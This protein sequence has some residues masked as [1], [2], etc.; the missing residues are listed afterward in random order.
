MPS[1]GKVSKQR[2]STCDKPL[3]DLF[4]EVVKHFD[5]FV[6]CGTRSKEDQEAAFN[7][8]NSKLHYP[9]S[10]HNNLPSKAIDVA[11]YLNGAIN[12]DPRECLYFAGVVKGIAAMMGIKIR[13]GGDWDSDNNI[14]ENKF[15]DLVHFEILE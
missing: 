3:I 12:W 5:C 14:I 8:G 7:A 2:L 15:N 13:Y 11:P 1:F 9:N 10:K 6:V 4:N